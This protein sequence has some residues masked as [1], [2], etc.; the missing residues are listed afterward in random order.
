MEEKSK[1]A[2][3][4]VDAEVASGEFTAIWNTIFELLTDNLTNPKGNTGKWIWSAYPENILAEAGTEKEI[5]AQ[6]PIVVISPIEKTFTNV[7]LDSSVKEYRIYF[8]IEIYSDRADYLDLISSEVERIF[9]ENKDKLHN[10]G[11]HNLSLVRTTYS[12]YY[13][14][15]VPI[16]MRYLRYEGDYE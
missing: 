9:N 11:L 10:K 5:R 4:Y 12:H 14:A 8:T 1:N 7:V 3:A 16:H 6:Y 13:R 15:A 2:Q